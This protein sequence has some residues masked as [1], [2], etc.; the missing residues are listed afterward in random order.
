MGKRLSALF[1]T[2]MLPWH[3][4]ED[5]HGVFQRMRLM[6]DAARSV[7]GE[8]TV[9]LLAP[10]EL[11]PNDRHL[12]RLEAIRHWMAGD[13]GDGFRVELTAFQSRRSALTTLIPRGHWYF[14]PSPLIRVDATAIAQIDAMIARCA[15]DAIVCHRLQSFGVLRHCPSARSIPW[16]LD[17]DD[18][19]HVAWARQVMMPPSWRSKRM[20]LIHCLPLFA[21]EFRALRRCRQVYVCSRRDVQ[22]LS[23]IDPQ[24]RAHEVP[25]TIPDPFP[26]VSPPAEG[27]GLGVLYV[28]TLTYAPN[29]V[30]LQWFLE[31]VWPRVIEEVPEARM[32]IIG[33]ASREFELPAAA[34]GTVDAL[35][36]VSEL[37]PA[38]AEAAAVVC[39]VLAG[40][41]TRI[42]IIEAAAHGR[43]V[44]STSVGAEGL[45]FQHGES[46][47][48]ADSV[49]DFARQLVDLLRNRD[50]R[51]AL[52]ESARREYLGRYERRSATTL[53]TQLLG[54]VR[55]VSMMEATSV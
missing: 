46:I 4:S 3:L 52:A 51:R 42:K 5:R 15:P 27:S 8:V 9:L 28:G 14:G 36:F 35:G 33:Q 13:L 50:R 19:E 22:R 34:T 16:A 7:F 53:L 24:G 11:R 10:S 20:R 37:T 6:M 47:L 31:H 38:Y 18:V 25:N 21:E 26:S 39:P 23:W 40:G 2:S 44:V 49:S 29:R 43:A 45:A 1:V 12:A 41:G 54:E 55:P 30:G 48:L 17:L 32:T